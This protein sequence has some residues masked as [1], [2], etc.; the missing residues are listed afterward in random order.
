MKKT[1][2]HFTFI[3]VLFTV[4]FASCTKESN[5]PVASFSISPNDTVDASTELTFTNT[6]TD[7]DTYLWNFGD[8][9]TSTEKNPT[10]TYASKAAEVPTKDPK[11]TTGCLSSY[12]VTLTAS[13]NGKS[14]ITSKTVTINYCEK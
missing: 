9:T 7:A 1:F 3:A 10:K 8:E 12:S 13:K 5:L 6:S 14:S 4:F 11:R 2:N